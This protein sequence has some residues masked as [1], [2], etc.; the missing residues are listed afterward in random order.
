MFAIWY[1]RLGELQGRSQQIDK[2]A[3]SYQ[4]AIEGN[5]RLDK[6]FAVGFDLFSGSG[7]FAI[8]A[9]LVVQRILFPRVGFDLETYGFDASIGIA[10]LQ[11]RWSPYLAL[12]VHESLQK[13]GITNSS[14]STTV[15]DGSM[16]S[17]RSSEIWGQ[18]A[19][20]EGGAQYVSSVGF[21]TELGLCMMVFQADDGHTAQQVFPVFSLRLAL[22]NRLRRLRRSGV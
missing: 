19:R 17:Y 20:I 7:M 9:G 8:D 2:N 18:H 10:P 13:L 14:G 15:G 22:V 12:G 5:P 4:R 1:R 21:T 16:A 6:Q 3:A 11:S